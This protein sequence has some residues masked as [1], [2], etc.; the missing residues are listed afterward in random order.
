MDGQAFWALLRQCKRGGLTRESG[1]G[2]VR[3]KLR[4][5]TLF[6]NIILLII[7]ITQV[8]R[9]LF[10]SFKYDYF[11][12]FLHILIIILYFW[13]QISR[14]NTYKIKK[15]NTFIQKFSTSAF[16]LTHES[17]VGIIN[18]QS[19][20]ALLASLYMLPIFVR[21]FLLWLLQQG[22]PS[23]LYLVCLQKSFCQRMQVVFQRFG[24]VGETA[25]QVADEGLL[26]KLL[27]GPKLG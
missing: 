4:R 13:R 23:L 9:L 22:K 15:V 20:A 3:S 14:I 18:K 17:Y 6:V 2:S 7:S 12:L 16:N 21:K 19:V 26:S 25:E 8:T 27:Y 1:T 5:C 10:T 24:V 11:K